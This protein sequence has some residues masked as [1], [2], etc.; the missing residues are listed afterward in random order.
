MT[1]SVVLARADRA[2]KIIESDI[3]M[4][5]WDTY[6]DRIMVEFERAKSNDTD[7]IMQLKR[8]LVSVNA[9]KAHFEALM[10]DGKIASKNIEL[11]QK[12][13][14]LQRVWGR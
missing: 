5:A 14:L 4:E 8:L 11:L 9:A 10:V 13:P 6:R 3:W 1:D 12:K 2:R 7:T